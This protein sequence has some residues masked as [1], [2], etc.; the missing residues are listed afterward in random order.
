MPAKRTQPST[1][2]KKRR[3]TKND[4]RL[5]TEQTLLFKLP[6][7]LRNEIYKMVLELG[8]YGDKSKGCRLYIKSHSHRSTPR[9]A[10]FRLLTVLRVSKLIREEALPLWLTHRIFIFEIR[11]RHLDRVLA[12]ARRTVRNYTESGFERCIRDIRVGID[13]FER[14]HKL[15]QQFVAAQ[16]T[17]FCCEHDLKL[18]DESTC[19]VRTPEHF[20]FFTPPRILG[21]QAYQEGWTDDTLQARVQEYLADPPQTSGGSS[22]A[23][24]QSSARVVKIRPVRAARN[25]SVSYTDADF[26]FAIEQKRAFV[27]RTRG[28]SMEESEIVINYKGRVLRTRSCFGSLEECQE[29]SA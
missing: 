9:D 20:S 25:K 26:T 16:L 6:G 29:V 1:G 11:G 22:A 17:K 28:Q 3:K 27:S 2:P 7:E 4:K 24:Q 12:W 15:E 23:S 13:M 8:D 10:D 5:P 19:W 18:H 14:T 21:F